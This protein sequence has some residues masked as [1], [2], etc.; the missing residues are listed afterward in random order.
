MFIY[1]FYKIGV[2][3]V[4]NMTLFLVDTFCI[5]VLLY[6]LKAA[7]NLNIS[8][9]NMFD[10]SND[11]SFANNFK[12]KEKRIM[13][14]CFIILFALPVFLWLFACSKHVGLKAAKIL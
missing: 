14:Q 7:K 6:G 11:C 1:F 9:C 12:I 8:A 13:K 5:P 2:A 10:N 4:R 3:L